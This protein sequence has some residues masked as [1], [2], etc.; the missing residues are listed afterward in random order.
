MIPLLILGLIWGMAA[1]YL[2]T[3]HFIVAPMRRINRQLLDVYNQAEDSA[4]EGWNHLRLLL[5]KH[6]EVISPYFE[7]VADRRKEAN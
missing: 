7:A 6:P 5:E 1:A 3:E 2:L 4:E